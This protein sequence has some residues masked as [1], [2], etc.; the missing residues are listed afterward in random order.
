MS[1]SIAYIPQSVSNLKVHFNT[2]LMPNDTDVKGILQNIIQTT[3]AGDCNFYITYK[4]QK[5]DFF[6]SVSY[7]EPLVS[8][9]K[10]IP[11]ATVK[12]YKS[13][14]Q[15]AVQQLKVGK[16]VWNT[17]NNKKPVGQHTFTLPK[18]D[19]NKIQVEIILGY[20]VKFDGGN[21]TP[22]PPT[23]TYNITLGTQTKG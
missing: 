8:A 2:N 1:Y 22:I 4:V 10:I 20:V 19:M 11:F 6:I 21:M 23:T 5:N 17:D 18:A 16:G 13:G 15:I 9:K 14:K 7:T 12:L 3:L